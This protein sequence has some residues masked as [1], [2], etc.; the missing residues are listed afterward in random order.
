[1]A[2]FRRCRLPWLSFRAT[3]ASSFFRFS[4]AS[5]PPSPISWAFCSTW[6]IY[7]WI[8]SQVRYFLAPPPGG[9]SVSRIPS[10]VNCW[11]RRVVF[12]SSWA[13]AVELAHSGTVPVST[14]GVVDLF[15]AVFFVVPATCSTPFSAA[16]RMAPPV[17]LSAWWWI[18]FFDLVSSGFFRASPPLGGGCLPIA[19]AGASMRNVTA[20]FSW[21]FLE[22]NAGP[23]APRTVAGPRKDPNRG[24]PCVFGRP[25]GTMPQAPPGAGCC[26]AAF[27]LVL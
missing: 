17:S 5:R 21:I 8:V 20:R 12:P 27:A 23:S 1:M 22:K 15:G 10:W 25:G 9:T 19:P 2:V 3:S 7:R 18:S 4:S 14:A 24:W 6:A 16:G 26:R 11:T 13:M